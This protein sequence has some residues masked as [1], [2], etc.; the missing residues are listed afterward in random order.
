MGNMSDKKKQIIERIQKMSGEY[1]VYQLF[2]DWISM[3]ALATA[4]AVDYKESREKAYLQIAGKHTKERME[5][6]CELNGIII[7]AFENEMSDILGFIYMHLELGSSRTGQFFT[8]Y[9]LCQLMAKMAYMSVGEKDIYTCNEPSCGGGGNIIAF[10]EELK[11]Q[12]I[13]YQTRMEAVCQDID[14]RAVYMTYVQCSYL[15]IPAVVYQSDTLRDPTGADS[16]TGR[17]Y[18][19]QYILNGSRKIEPQESEG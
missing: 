16:S 10:A 12:G 19:P 14:I 11:N 5:Q 1:S 6:F 3:F 18:T 8:P 2:D 17:L 13:N 9:H 15:G 7:D 4:Q